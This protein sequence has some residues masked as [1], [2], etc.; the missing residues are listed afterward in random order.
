M[1]NGWNDFE[2]NMAAG[3]TSCGVCYWLVPAFNSG[4]SGNQ[5]WTSYAGEQSSLAA[6]PRRRWRNSWAT[7]APR[8]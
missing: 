5:F 4:P 1:T 2:Y 3:A 7:G 6:L 8:Q